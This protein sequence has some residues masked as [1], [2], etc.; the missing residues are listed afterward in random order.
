MKTKL[1]HETGMSSQVHTVVIT[2][3]DS[4]FNTVTGMVTITTTNQVSLN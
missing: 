3:T 4:C 2:A 1:P